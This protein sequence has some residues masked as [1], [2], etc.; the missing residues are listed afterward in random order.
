M[1]R[2]ILPLLCAS[3]FTLSLHAEEALFQYDFSDLKPGPLLGQDGWS[4]YNPGPDMRS[5]SP[6]VETSAQ[7]PKV[8]VGQTEDGQKLMSRGKKAVKVDLKNAEKFALEFDICTNGGQSV[9]VMGLGNSSTFPP[10]VGV[11]FDSLILREQDF[12]GKIHKTYGPDGKVFKP[13]PEDWY[14]VRTE[15][16]YVEALGAWTGTMAIKNLTLDEKE[17][18]SLYFDAEQKQKAAP[19]GVFTAPTSKEF[20]NLI[21][22]RTGTPGGKVAN[23]RIYQLDR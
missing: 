19:L 11:L 4:D 2:V 7:E 18:T 20:W 21:A 5:V 23:F 8:F 14:T 10:T 15:W 3:A 6:L 1:T 16:V 13:N 22:L 17:F 12:S 9:A